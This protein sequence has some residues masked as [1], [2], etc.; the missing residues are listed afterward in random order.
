MLPTKHM[1]K[2]LDKVLIGV[3]ILWETGNNLDMYFYSVVG[4]GFLLHGISPYLPKN[5]G[6]DLH[7]FIKTALWNFWRV[8]RLVPNS[9]GLCTIHL[10]NYFTAGATARESNYFKGDGWWVR[11]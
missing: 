7:R 8:D 9:S 6:I 5:Q 1:K 2:Q 11:Q 3:L 10:R 4:T